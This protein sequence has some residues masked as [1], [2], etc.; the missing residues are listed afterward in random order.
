M[1]KKKK[2]R[3]PPRVDS[4]GLK[5]NFKVNLYKLKFI[6]I[7]VN[8]VPFIWTVF[9]SDCGTLAHCQGLIQFQV[10]FYMTIRATKIMSYF[11]TQILFNVL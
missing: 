8:F 6:S 5:K 7:R 4:F 1:L 3:G 11:M 9:I 2:K 10:A